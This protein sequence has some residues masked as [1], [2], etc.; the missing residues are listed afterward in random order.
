MSIPVRRWQRIAAA[1]ILA[2]LWLSPAASA[3]EHE[4]L[5]G[6]TQRISLDEIVERI[7]TENPSVRAA[8]LHADALS[9]V[10]DQVSAWP[11]PT[12]GVAYQPMPMLTAHGAQR[13]EW[14]VEQEVPFPGMLGLREK[15]ASL[16]AEVSLYESDALLEE[17]I[18]EAKEAYFELYRLNETERLISSFEADL[19][20]YEEVAAVRYEVGQG[21]QQALL[22]AQLEKNQLIL[23]LHHLESARRRAAETLARLTNHP[24][25]PR[26][27]LVA[28]PVLPGTKGLDSVLLTERAIEERPEFAALEAAAEQAARQVDLAR[29]EAY[30]DFDLR[31][32]YMDIA[33]RDV[34]PTA[35]GRDAV[36]IG[37]SIKIPLQRGPIKARIE[38]ARLRQAQVEA[39]Q[40]A[41]RTQFRTEIEELLAALDHEAEALDSYESTLLPQATSTVEASLSAYSTG[42]VGFL[43]LLDAERTIFS[44]RTAYVDAASRYLTLAARLER[45]LGVRALTDLEGLSASAASVIR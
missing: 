19:E 20:G 1:P 10:P 38:E 13:S 41:L 9:T 30:P 36:T 6:T 16:D 39:E 23:R 37:A 22:K 44:L 35:N 26:Y 14:M 4:H 7:V 8:R 45:V 43:D 21:S 29:K 42:S 17:L 2:L 25:G 18:L 24:E 12:V 11:D 15:I 28:E 34:P 5:G 31:L 40:E 27:F 32:S 3:Q 33:A